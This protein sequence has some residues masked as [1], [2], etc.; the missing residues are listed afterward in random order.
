MRVKWSRQ[1]AWA[2]TQ[3][4]SGEVCSDNV[5]WTGRVNIAHFCDLRNSS[6]HEV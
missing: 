3:R 1:G 4:K 5:L 6:S 2:L